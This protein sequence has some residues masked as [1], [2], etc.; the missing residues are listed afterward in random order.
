MDRLIEHAKSHGWEVKV[1]GRQI[2]V[3]K[4]GHKIESPFML[5]SYIDSMIESMKAIDE[6]YET[7]LIIS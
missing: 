2:I 6:Y 7:E 1:D 5:V 3:T 4:R